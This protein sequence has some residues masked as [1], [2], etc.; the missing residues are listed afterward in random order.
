MNP[1][2]IFNML[3]AAVPSMCQDPEGRKALRATIDLFEGLL[4]QSA[5]PYGPQVNPQLDRALQQLKAKLPQAE[6]EIR[7]KIDEVKRQLSAYDDHDGVVTFPAVR[8]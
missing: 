5:S 2:A 1:L 7:A 6:A 4:Y 3:M 8:P